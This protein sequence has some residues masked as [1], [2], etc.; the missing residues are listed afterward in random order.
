MSLHPQGENYAS[1]GSSG[2]VIVHS[3]EPDNFGQK[4]STLISGREKFGMFC[5]YVGI[6]LLL[7]PRTHIS[8]QSPDGRRVAMSSET[9]QIFIFD[10]ESSALSITFTSHAMAVRSVA[11]SPDSNVSSYLSSLVPCD[12]HT[13]TVVVIE[14]FRR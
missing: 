10:I 14:C 5:A 8:L 11:W 2:N 6:F 9:G 3:A 13:M 1:T 4:L 7:F 12:E